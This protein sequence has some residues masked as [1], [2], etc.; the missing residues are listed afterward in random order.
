LERRLAPQ[1]EGEDDVRDLDT[2]PAPKLQQ[3]AEPVELAQPVEPIGGVGAAWNDEP[4]LLEVAQHSGR[5]A[6]PPRRLANR[7]LVHA[8]TLTQS[9]QSSGGGRQMPARP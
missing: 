6:R 7:Q 3:G 8:P 5:P 1:T 2:E 4:G 9:C